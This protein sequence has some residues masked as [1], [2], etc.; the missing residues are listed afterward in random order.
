[1]MIH[2]QKIKLTITW[3]NEKYM[4]ALIARDSFQNITLQHRFYWQGDSK[5]NQ[6]VS[7]NGSQ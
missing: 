6:S 5:A 7:Q 1:M 3:N 2:V 4:S